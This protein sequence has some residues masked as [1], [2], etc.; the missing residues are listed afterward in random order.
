METKLFS[1]LQS[2]ANNIVKMKRSLPKRAR[3]YND[4]IN[5]LDTSNK[6][7]KK[8]K[9]PKK[10]KVEDL[11]FSVGSALDGGGGG[12]NGG[13][14]LG[15]LLAAFGIRKGANF[16]K[17]KLGLPKGKFKGSYED[18]IK[19]IN[20]KG[21]LTKGENFALRD[22]KRLVGKGGISN[23][24]AAFNALH[25]NSRNW[26]SG[27]NVRGGGFSAETAAQYRQ[28]GRS[29]GGGFKGAPRGRLGGIAGPLNIAFAGLDFMGRKGEGQ[30]N[31]QAGVGAA[32]G[33]LGGLAGAEAGA[34]AGAAIGALFGGVGAVPG[35]I[36]GGLI[37]G[38]G[39]GQ[40]GGNLADKFT[41][42][43]KI[44]ERLKAQE[45]KQ[46][47]AASASNVTFA[48]ITDKFDKVV[49]KFEKIAG[50]MGAAISGKQSSDVSAEDKMTEYGEYGD[51]DQTP[52]PTPGELQDLESTGGVLPSSSS[53]GDKFG[54]SSW[55]GRNHNGIDYPLPEGTPISVIQP[56]TVAD[57]G[58]R[59]NGYG[60]Q[61]K[62]NHPGGVSSFYA[63]L[64][65][66]NVASGQKIDPGTVIGKIGT[67]G[68]STGPHLHFEV[69]VN[70]K[71]SNP[72]PYEDKLF[73]FGG[74]VKVK[75]KKGEQGAPDQKINTI[76]KQQSIEDFIKGT[77]SGDR[78]LNDPKLKAQ[79]TGEK[80]QFKN[81]MVKTP[82][83]DPEVKQAQ[84][85]YNAYVRDIR[86]RQ[87]DQVK[88]QTGDQI[89]AQILTP[90]PT[91][92]QQSAIFLMGD[93]SQQVAS[94]PQVV[95]IP[96][97]NGGG[98]GGVTVITP[99]EG[100]ILNS[101][102]TTMLLTNLSSA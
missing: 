96:I 35:A 98:G 47:E 18:I 33:A 31:L 95:P 68:H 61:V 7:I 1:S 8:I 13:G 22:Y 93:Q 39:G 87:Q 97:G 101:L 62:V 63:H 92:A 94:Q 43:D 26:Y 40:L 82:V 23:E 36:I 5:W 17:G 16:L 72:E 11:Q 53:K 59:D 4:F 37:G 78:I 102:W 90:P 21:N 77:K 89:P 100:Q 27:E 75:A 86:S 19:K 24:S 25:R 3:D 51:R 70:G 57:A 83:S 34:A 28:A 49:S 76:T 30:S 46:R 9:L 14:I 91:A 64:S 67:T 45:T 84:Q 12:G 55:R 2:S 73:R 80:Y 38:F 48:S 58:F 79:L 50:G 32:G 20:K 71:V 41:G 65:S 85:M 29:G 54:Y 81:A 69:D 10:K 42:A 74:N 60:N 6:D 88:A 99:S 66:I 15:S 44:D 52:S 56:G